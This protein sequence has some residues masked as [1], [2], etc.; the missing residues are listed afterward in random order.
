[1][2]DPLTAAP[3]DDDAGSVE[4]NAGSPDE[5]DQAAAASSGP[6][7]LA[8]GLTGVAVLLGLALI[9]AAVATSE[10]FVRRRI[11]RRYR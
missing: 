7:R 9:T 3:T 11:R 4:G 10:P 1:L 2:V 8:Q 5:I 6:S